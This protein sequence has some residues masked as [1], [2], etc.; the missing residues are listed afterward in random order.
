L[1]NNFGSCVGGLCAWHMVPHRKHSGAFISQKWKLRE[2]RWPTELT[3]F[4][5][6]KTHF[7]F[8]KKGRFP[9]YNR[10]NAFIPSLSIC[11]VTP[12]VQ[13]AEGKTVRR[14]SAV[15]ASLKL[16]WMWLATLILTPRLTASFQDIQHFLKS[17]RCILWHPRTFEFYFYSLDSSEN[18]VWNL[19]PQ[20]WIWGSYN[21]SR[22]QLKYGR[23]I[24]KSLSTQDY[25]GCLK[26][27]ATQ[28]GEGLTSG[29]SGWR[30]GLLIIWTNPHLPSTILLITHSL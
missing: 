25:W 7:F 14:V 6:K 27:W 12:A 19:E 15:S 2:P 8:F 21:F 5:E 30:K 4:L 26:T 1:Q 16:H 10:K 22:N 17:L 9:L 20:N 23:M 3:K 29:H 24:P 11:Y 18:W 13:Y 28:S